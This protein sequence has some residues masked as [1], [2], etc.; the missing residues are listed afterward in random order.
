[1]DIGSIYEGII[2]GKVKAV[3]YGKKDIKD[4]LCYVLGNNVQMKLISCLDE[5]QCDESVCIY[6]DVTEQKDNISIELKKGETTYIK[7][8]EF[9]LMFNDVHIPSN[10][11]VA[12]WG[13]GAELK[14]LFKLILKYC[15]PA[16]I[17][18]KQKDGDFE[19]VP[20]VKPE[21]I[22]VKDFFIIITT[23]KFASE[24]KEILDFSGCKIG[25]DY[26]HGTD[27]SILNDNAKM[28]VKVITDKSLKKNICKRPFEYVNVGERGNLTHCCYEWLPKYIG[29]VF[30]GEKIADTITSRIIRISFMN[31]TYSF[32]NSVCCPFMSSDRKKLFLDKQEINDELYLKNQEIVDV[33]VAFDNTCNLRCESCRSEFIVDKSMES[34]SIAN[35]I[36]DYLIPESRRIT[37]AGNGEAFLSKA[38]ARIFNGEYPNIDLTILS[39]GNLF[40]FDKWKAVEGHFKSVTMM[41]SVDAASKETYELVRRGGKWENLI[42]GLQTAS[43]LRKRNLIKRFIIRFVVSKRNYLEMPRFVQLGIDMGCDLVDFTRIEN[44]GTFTDEEFSDISMFINDQPKTELRR[45]LDLPIMGEKIVRYTNIIR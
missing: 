18:D 30:D 23:T 41:F 38:Y 39:N 34:L 31:Q 25:K 6:D 33:D 21:S 20:F 29:N 45:I 2:K 27:P 24:I 26:I 40:T 19:G 35:Q 3:F 15:Q 11:Q 1:M 37:V 43:E 12:L 8:S 36:C 28:F 10:R 7:L 44:W 5:V 42:N 13:G 9:V 16:V 4:Y 32:C 14:S 17:I 22:N